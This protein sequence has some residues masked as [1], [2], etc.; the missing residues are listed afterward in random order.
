MTVLRSE[1]RDG[2]DGASCLMT[3]RTASR[4]VMYAKR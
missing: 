3:E 1:S 4:V 2:S